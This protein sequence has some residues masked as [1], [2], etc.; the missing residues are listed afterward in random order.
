MKRSDDWLSYAELWSNSNGTVGGMMS[1]GRSSTAQFELLVMVPVVGVHA[2][3]E[4]DLH[5]GQRLG[6]GPQCAKVKSTR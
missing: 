3:P 6:F 4:V 2:L 1:S 5:I